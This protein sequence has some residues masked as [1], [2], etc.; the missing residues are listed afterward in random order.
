VTV[1]QVDHLI[2]GAGL[3]GVEAAVGIAEVAPGA[4]V[5][6]L[7]AESEIP[8]DRPPLS[9]GLWTGAVPEPT[10]PELPLGATLLPGRRAVHLDPAGRRVTDDA[11]ESWQ[12]G[13]L[14]L[15]TGGEPRRLAEPAERVIHFRTLADYRRLRELTREDS[16]VIVIGGGF[17]G[18]ELAAALTLTGRR[19]TLLMPEPGLGARVFPGDLSRHLATEFTGRGVEVRGGTT[20]T[21]VRPSGDGVVVEVAGGEAIA[22]E[23]AVVAIGIEP[24]TGLASRAGLRVEDGIVV[25]RDFVTSD[26]R[27]YAAGDVARFPD[28]A[29]GVMRRVEHEDHARHSGRQA[30]RNMAG[31]G[32]PYRHRPMFYGDL[33]ALGYEAVGDLDARSRTV[34]AWRTPYREG[35]VF[36]VGDGVIRGILLWNTWNRVDRARDLLGAPAPTGSVL[37]DLA[38]DGTP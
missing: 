12:Y 36:Y 22:G 26:A 4:Q 16:R 5:T 21:G 3:A 7:S 24:S 23:L 11:G 35:V 20:V 6:L 28:A 19:V 33:F 27:V 32:E 29:L 18:A 1:H 38:G 30:G 8:Y 37:P 31:A 13:R 15:A 17:L 34:A 14:L 25:G 10:R 9:K 2:V